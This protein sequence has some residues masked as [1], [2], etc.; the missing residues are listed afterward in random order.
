MINSLIYNFFAKK[1]RIFLN[2]F[3]T[4]VP[5]KSSLATS[6]KHKKP[7]FFKF[8]IIEVLPDEGPPVK[9]IFLILT[10]KLSL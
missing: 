7:N 5:K 8:L 10:F 6:S 2:E 4:L 1:Q 9:T 3:N